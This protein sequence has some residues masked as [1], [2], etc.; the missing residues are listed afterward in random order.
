MKGDTYLRKPADFTRLYRQ[1][2]YF[3]HPLLA[4]KSLP[5]DLAYPRWGVVVSKKL[6]T[7]VVR[8]YTKR[9]LREILRQAHLKPGRDI[10]I[11]TR[12]GAAAAK[13]G[14]LR[15]AVLGLLEKSGLTEKNEIISP[16]AN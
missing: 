10:I 8:N 4:V 12:Q 15:Q 1:G 13:F 6:G 11:V 7:A 16:G 3:S 14:D 9:R 5:N 2:K